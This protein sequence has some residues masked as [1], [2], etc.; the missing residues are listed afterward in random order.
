MSI[1]KCLL[2][3]HV[4]K[5]KLLGS[6]LEYLL[7]LLWVLKCFVLFLKQVLECRLLLKPVVESL[8]QRLW[9]VKYLLIL[10]YIYVSLLPWYVIKCI[11]LRNFV[12]HWYLLRLI[13]PNLLIHI[14]MFQRWIWLCCTIDLVSTV[15]NGTMSKFSLIIYISS[16]FLIRW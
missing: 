14:C 2:P 4:I 8:L 9:I 15:L 12:K 10:V 6:I 5:C 13:I 3:G 7:L 16:H 11:L 1:V